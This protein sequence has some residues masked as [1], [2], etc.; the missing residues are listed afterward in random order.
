MSDLRFDPV[1]G[2]WTLVAP[3]RENRPVE[4]LPVEKVSERSVCPFCGGNESETPTALALY[5][6]AGTVLSTCDSTDDEWIS[7]VVPNKYASFGAVNPQTNGQSLDP[8][9][10]GP[11]TTSSLPGPQEL[12]IPTPRHISSL[13]ELDDLE[14]QV[15]WQASQDRIALMQSGGYARHAMLFMNCRSQAGASLAHVHV[16]LIGSPVVTSSLA[17]RVQRN[18]D[19]LERENKTLVESIVAWELKEDHRI[20]SQSENFTV[21]C[22]FASRF[23]YQ[24]W[25]VP[26]RR[27]VAFIDLDAEQ[28]NELGQLCRAMTGRLEKRLNNPP[29]NMLLRMAPFDQAADDHWYVEILP[30]TTR[31]AGFELGTDVWVNPMPPELAAK[32]LRS[33][34]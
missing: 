13:S 12:L 30:R 32:H 21:L 29:Y 23:A 7:R 31:A 28:R 33:C 11:F 26:K 9:D 20:I 6:S 5:D 4:L 16:Q 15:L 19:C 1:S 18:R 8:L 3:N 25:I 17:G 10:R 34:S 2:Q 27:D 24:T 14:T 22:P